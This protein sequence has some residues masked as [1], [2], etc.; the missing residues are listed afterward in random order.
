MNSLT[1]LI[2]LNVVNSLTIQKVLKI[3]NSLTIQKVLKI[4]NTQKIKSIQKIKNIQKIEN[5]LK[6]VRNRRKT[7]KHKIC[8]FKNSAIYVWPK[9]RQKIQNIEFENLKTPLKILKN[10]LKIPKLR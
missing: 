2:S 3:E 5:T 9:I 6:S 7:A 10:N 8:F 4:E 1:I